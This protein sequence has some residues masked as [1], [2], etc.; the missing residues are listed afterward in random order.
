MR[1]MMT[2]FAALFLGTVAAQGADL[3]FKDT[4]SNSGFPTGFY[5]SLGAGG[6]IAD[7]AAVSGNYA[8]SGFEGSGR[9]GYDFRLPNST[10][11]AG[12]FGGISYE[13]LTG[14]GGNQAFGYEAG[15][16]AGT[17]IG[18]VAMPYILLA[19]QGQHLGVSGP[20]FSTDLQGVKEGFGVS[21]NLG[22]KWTLD[23][24]L[25]A[26]QYVTSTSGNATITEDDEALWII[27]DKKS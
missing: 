18:N 24:E 12:A 25:D 26:V 11:V 20:G 23:L 4:T 15:V 14:N 1:L 16:R 19:Y 3:S 2:A 10:I 22:S 21:T 8:F 27:P 9:T 5:V 7:A 13:G 6:A 17:V